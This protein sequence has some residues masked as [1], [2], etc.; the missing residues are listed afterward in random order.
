MLLL[1]G[2][3]GWQVHAQAQQARSLA[4]AQ[5]S[6]LAP[7]ATTPAF[8]APS[9]AQDAAGNLRRFE[10]ILLPHDEIP[11]LVQDLLQWA[12]D[13]GLSIERGDYQA[14]ADSEGGFM[15]YRMSLPVRGKSTA[16]HRLILKALSAQKNL[17]L[18]SL[19]FKREQVSSEVIEARI[20]WLA[21]TQMPPSWTAAGA[22]QPV[23]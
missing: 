14:D 3:V 19:Q 1:I 8:T 15:R 17:T 21:M 11:Q 4:R 22:A 16:V 20:Q 2:V 10:R 7:V 9:D 5:A 12:Q 23:R 13:E 6:P 18:E